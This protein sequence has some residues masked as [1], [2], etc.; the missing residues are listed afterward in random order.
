MIDIGEDTLQL[1]ANDQYVYLD[2]ISLPSAFC[3]VRTMIQERR[4]WVYLAKSIADIMP[5]TNIRV[6]KQ[7]KPIQDNLATEQKGGI[8]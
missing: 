5:N 1:Q 2:N 4:A 8:L 3:N 6:S 7:Y